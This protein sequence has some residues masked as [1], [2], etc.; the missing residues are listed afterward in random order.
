MKPKTVAKGVLEARDQGLV[1]FIGITV[2]SDM[3]I[4]LK[5]LDMFDFDTIL[6]PVYVAAMTMPRLEN[7]FRPVLRTAM[8][9]DIGVIAIKSIAK[10]RYDGEKNI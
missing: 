1:K 6:I 4:A 5:A 10:N 2:H 3:R 7:D 8:D 9:R